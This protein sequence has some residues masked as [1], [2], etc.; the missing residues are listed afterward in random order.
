LLA[1]ASVLLIL[2]VVAGLFWLRGGQVSLPGVASMVEQ[3]VESALSEID[4]EIGSVLY[5]M[6][7]GDNPSGIEAKDVVI[8]GADGEALLE[9]PSVRA[10]VSLGDVIQGNVTPRTLTV[11]GPTGQIRRNKTGDLTLTLLSD[12]GEPRIGTE[13][14]LSDLASLSSLDILDKVDELSFSEARL[15]YVNERAGTEWSADDSS[16][17]LKNSDA[18]L[19]ARLEASLSLDGI[20]TIPVTRSNIS[21]KPSEKFPI[22]EWAMVS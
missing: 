16:F 18:G 13:R 14:S 2:A 21:R 6:A 7:E 1:G 11:I 12:G 15:D 22:E 5:A 4:L 3:E 17:T 19:S 20:R 9:A 10:E 8:R